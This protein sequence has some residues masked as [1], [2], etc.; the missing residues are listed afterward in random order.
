MHTVVIEAV[1]AVLV[2]ELEAVHSVGPGKSSILVQHYS[3]IGWGIFC[4]AAWSYKIQAV[5]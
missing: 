3:W 1:E 2:G 4:D 5:G